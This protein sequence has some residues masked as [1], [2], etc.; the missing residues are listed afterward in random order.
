MLL[1]ALPAACAL[2]AF[3]PAC[4]A[5]DEPASLAT[6]STGESP[7]SPVGCEG[8]V[9]CT[10]TP[11]AAIEPVLALGKGRSCFTPLEA[12]EVLPI[13]FGPQ[14]GFHV[15]LALRFGGLDAGTARVSMR[16]LDDEAQPFGLE[17]PYEPYVRSCDA[18]LGYY[19]VAPLYGLLAAT[20]PG[21]ADGY[22][23]RTMHLAARIE[24]AE[25]RH[26]EAESQI[27][28]GEILYPG[29]GVTR[30]RARG[31]WRGAAR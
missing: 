9:P 31:A 17:D 1:R 4:V 13:V 6:S 3:A 19:E 23:G 5:A 16:L 29:G 10:P 22:V 25:G 15:W 28:L 24:D 21:E 11:P 14:G 18:G 2:L 27:V 12:G 30:G 20:F 8:Y 26:A 7:S